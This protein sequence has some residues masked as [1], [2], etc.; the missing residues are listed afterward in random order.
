MS[1][2]FCCNDAGYGLF[3]ILGIK[4][5]DINVFSVGRITIRNHVKSINPCMSEHAETRQ[6][7]WNER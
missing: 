6:T 3:S 2:N 7:Q 5:Q 1:T 4:A